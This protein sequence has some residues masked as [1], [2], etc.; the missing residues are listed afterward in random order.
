[1]TNISNFDNF[2]LNTEETQNVEGGWGCYGGRTR[3]RRTY[4]SYSG[5]S[6]YSGSYSYGSCYSGSYSYSSCCSGSSCEPEVE[7]EA[8]VEQP[9]VIEVPG[10]DLGAPIDQI[11]GPIGIMGA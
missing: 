3:R 6:C 4:S 2:A 11:R 10:I 7:V 9:P 5:G 1:M 8:V